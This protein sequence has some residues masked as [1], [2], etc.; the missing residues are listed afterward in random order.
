[1]SFTRS[2]GLFVIIVC[3]LSQKAAFAKEV[4]PADVLLEDKLCYFVVKDS[5]TEEQLAVLVW[6]LNDIRKGVITIKWRYD[7]K[8]KFGFMPF[9]TWNTQISVV[10]TS[11][12]WGKGTF[13]ALIRFDDRV[14][15]IATNGKLK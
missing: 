10:V 8:R 6:N 12:D 5:K 1:M 7:E 3:V 13:S 11:Y 9:M 2:I 14:T 15:N 4:Y